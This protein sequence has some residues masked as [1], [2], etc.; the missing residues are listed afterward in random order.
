[1]RQIV[2]ID[3]EKIGFGLSKAGASESQRKQQCQ[4]D[5]GVHGIE[6]RDEVAALSLSLSERSGQRLEE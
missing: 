5:P 2:G 4:Y 3:E 1:M 6:V